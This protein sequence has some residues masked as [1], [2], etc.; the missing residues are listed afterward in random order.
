MPARSSRKLPH[1]ATMAEDDA[2]PAAA[3][4]A[5]AAA[6]DDDSDVEMSGECEDY[7]VGTHR[8]MRHITCKVSLPDGHCAKICGR[9]KGSA[10]TKLRAVRLPPLIHLRLALFGLE[11]E[12]DATMYARCPD[13]CVCRVCLTSLFFAMLSAFPPLPTAPP[14]T[15]PTVPRTHMHE[16]QIRT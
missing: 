10:S 4:A 8:R 12:V 15:A 2:K 5:A 14:V 7:A 3:A 6:D 13:L 1:F 11:P 9:A 16:H